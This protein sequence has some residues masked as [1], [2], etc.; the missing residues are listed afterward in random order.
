MYLQSNIIRRLHPRRRVGGERWDWLKSIIITLKHNNRPKEQEKLRLCTIYNFPHLLPGR[1]QRTPKEETSPEPGVSVSQSRAEAEGHIWG[2][3]TPEGPT[4]HCIGQGLW[5]TTD[6][7]AS[8]SWNRS[9][10]E[11]TLGQNKAST[12]R[13]EIHHQYQGG[14]EC[15]SHT[16]NPNLRGG[17]RGVEKG[18]GEEHC[19]G[20][21]HCLVSQ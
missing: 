19:C 12:W 18:Q 3:W 7:L 8:Q 9:A 21:C 4:F 16:P 14:A 20:V 13:V 11:A 15:W 10:S 6:N 5:S 1:E 2:W 17:R